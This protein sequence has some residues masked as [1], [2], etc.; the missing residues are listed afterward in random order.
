MY[1]VTAGLSG[2]GK[3]LAGL[4]VKKGYNVAVI[5]TDQTKCTEIADQYDLL[6]ICGSATDQATL[7]A[8]GLDR[9][10]TF[11]AATGDDS[12]NLMACMTAKR[13]VKTVISVVN[14]KEHEELFRDAEIRICE[15]RDEIAARS[16]LIGLEHPNAQILTAIEGGCI[17]EITVSDGSKGCGKTVREADGGRD[18]LYV[19]VRRGGEL[20]IPN[21]DLVFQAGD[22]IVI[23]TKKNDEAKSVDK[24]NGLFH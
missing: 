1:L 17:F 15:N 21:G 4:A 12:V 3:A 14:E 8:A 13:R 20:I 7:E 18:I 10:D 9:A 16:L 6:A 24:M 2:M 19:A 23:F 22:V 5:D 11:V